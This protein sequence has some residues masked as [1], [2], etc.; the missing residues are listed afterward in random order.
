MADLQTKGKLRVFETVLFSKD[1]QALETVCCDW[2]CAVSPGCQV[3]NRSVQSTAGSCCG[4]F[5]N[6]NKKQN[7]TRHFESS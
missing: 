3:G 6:G 5:S 1:V 7:S 4:L 2:D